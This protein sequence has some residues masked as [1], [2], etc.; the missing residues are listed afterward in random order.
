MAVISFFIRFYFI[1]NGSVIACFRRV[2]LKI[3]KGKPQKSVF[4][5]VYAYAL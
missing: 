4:G 3:G 5:N 1:V 2:P